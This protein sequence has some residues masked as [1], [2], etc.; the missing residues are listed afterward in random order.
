MIAGA[1]LL[2]VP[3]FGL[4]S[5]PAIQGYIVT[6]CTVGAFLGT[7]VVSPW[8]LDTQVGGWLGGSVGGL[9]DG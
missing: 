8:A 6:A 1:L 3:H 2:I 4:E 5:S 9:V 7:V